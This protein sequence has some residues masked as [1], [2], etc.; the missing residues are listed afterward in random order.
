MIKHKEIWTLF[1][2]IRTKERSVSEKNSIKEKK[3]ACE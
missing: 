3:G 1:M 2:H